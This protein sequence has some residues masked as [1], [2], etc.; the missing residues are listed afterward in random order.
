MV[1]DIRRIKAR[2]ES[3]RLPP[4][5]DADFHLK[6]GP[7]GLSDVEFLTQMFQLV[8]G[9]ENPEMRVTGTFQALHNLRSA[10]ILTT[11][12]YNSLN[13]SYL[14][15]TRVRLRLHL[16]SGRVSNSLPTDPDSAAR[17][18]ASLGFDRTAELREQ[19]RRYTRRARRTF[20]RLFYE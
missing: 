12:D 20:E 7:G 1:H 10:E 6:L 11:A 4:A 15:C 5:E 14:F 13:D 8:H 18:A 9:H 3:E 16:Q 19:Y 2:V 17:L